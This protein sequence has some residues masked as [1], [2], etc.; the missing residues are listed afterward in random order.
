MF[1]TVIDCTHNMLP[2][3]FQKSG[4]FLGDLFDRGQ[5]LSRQGSQVDPDHHQHRQVSTLRL[6]VRAPLAAHRA[7]RHRHLQADLLQQVN[8]LLKDFL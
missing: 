8:T 1:K 4:C 6:L 3:D 5:R 7:R 2:H